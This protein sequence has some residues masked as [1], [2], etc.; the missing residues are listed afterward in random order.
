MRAAYC[1]GEGG[2]RRGEGR[3]GSEKNKTKRDVK[4]KRNNEV[5][6]VGKEKDK[7]VKGGAEEGG[8]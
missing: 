1:R 7:H 3:D 8:G 2:G 6:P 4:S 5:K